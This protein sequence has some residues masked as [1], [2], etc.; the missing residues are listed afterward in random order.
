[1]YQPDGYSVIQIH[2]IDRN[3]PEEFYFSGVYPNP[4]NN[5]TSIKFGLSEASDVQVSIYGVDG[6]IIDHIAD[7]YFQ[8]GHHTLAYQANELTTGTYIVRITTSH[9]Q[10]TVKMLL[11]R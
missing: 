5:S 7:G 6:R 11:L 2:R 1:M 4:F 10:K 3:T 9:G 8:A